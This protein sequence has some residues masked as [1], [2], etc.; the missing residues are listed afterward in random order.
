MV[1]CEPMA[2]DDFKDILEPFEKFIEIEILGQKVKVPENNTLL[3]CFQYLS[4]DSVS[5]GDFCWNRDCLNCQVWIDQKGKE[6][7]LIACR[8]KAESGMK[9]VR[10][11]D[12]LH[13]DDL[14]INVE[15]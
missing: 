13:L 5:R 8:S 7:G 1:F 12:E 4:L 15:E 14:G 3:R 6:K 10:L 9:I 11:H 2:L